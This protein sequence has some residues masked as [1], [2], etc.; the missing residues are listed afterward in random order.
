MDFNMGK[1]RNQSTQNGAPLGKRPEIAK[2]KTTTEAS[3]QNIPQ[4]TQIPDSEMIRQIY[5]KMNILDAVNHKLDNLLI[6]MDSIEGKVKTIETNILELETGTSYIEQ[7]VITIK[8]DVKYLQENQ[9]T[10]EKMNDIENE[11]VDLSNRARRNTVIIHN[12]PEGLEN[13][14][15]YCEDFAKDFINKH[16]KLP[17]SDNILIER[18]HRTPMG[19]KNQRM[20]K[21][22]PIHVKFVISKDRN[23]VLEQSKT[24]LK[25]NPLNGNHIWM[26]DSVHK[27]TRIETQQLVEKKKELI[28]QGKWAFI[29]WTIPR[30]LKYKEA[31]SKG[32]WKTL[33]L[34]NITN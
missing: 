29:S 15:G 18:A 4:P 8:D 31:E 30:V 32:P 22:R 5:D 27:K 11:I 20:Q 34:E 10:R 12:V 17:D 1:S 21:P 3:S 14:N 19:P 33:K 2:G 13:T 7:D 28:S 23:R 6:R 25:N 16:M 24:L 9:V 26:S